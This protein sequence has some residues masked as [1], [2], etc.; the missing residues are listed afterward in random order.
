MK[1]LLKEILKSPQFSEGSAWTRKYYKTNETVVKEGEQ[2]TTLFFVEEGELRVSRRVDL[3][4]NKHIQPG[5]GDLKEGAIFGESCLHIS[6]PRIATVT[7]VTPIQLLEING[8]SLGI[9]LD[10]HPIKGYLFYKKLFEVV[11]ARLNN[12]NKTVETLMAWGLNAHEID[13]HL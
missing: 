4:N 2:G 12:S 13:K 3:E 8:E 6:L 9:Y 10:D 5:V 1:N 7:A 11:I